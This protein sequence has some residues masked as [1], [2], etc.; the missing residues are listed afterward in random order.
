MSADL[1]SVH[2]PAKA[3]A[4]APAPTTAQPKAELPAAAAPENGPTYF[5]TIDCL[6][7]ELVQSAAMIRTAKSFVSRL[8]PSERVGLF[9]YPLGPKVEATT[10]HAEVLAALDQVYGQNVPPP[11]FTT[12]SRPSPHAIVDSTNP[13]GGMGGEIY[14]VALQEEAQ[15][16]ASLGMLSAS[17][18]ALRALP[19]RKVVV[20]VSS[21]LI[22][23]DKPGYRPDL[24]DRGIGIGKEAAGSN[25]TI[26]SLFVDQS[27]MTY[28]AARRPLE[29][30]ERINRDSEILDRYLDQVSGASGGAMLTSLTDDGAAAFNRILDETSSFYQLGIEA[31]PGDRDGKP[32]ALAVKTS[33]HGATVRARS[34]VLIPKP[35][36]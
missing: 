27:F 10:N 6:S 35:G 11:G 2:G 32:Q 13:H 31:E 33:A 21:G 36:E 5:L 29:Q 25:A 1:V 30:G 23:A 4:T 7:F 34:W 17:M 14:R 28:G 9:A 8:G 3:D 22:S 19:G 20:L 24:G 12:D 26:Y 16:T 15:N 18:R